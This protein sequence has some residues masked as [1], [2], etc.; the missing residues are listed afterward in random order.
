MRLC[1]EA[2]KGVETEPRPRFGHLLG[3]GRGAEFAIS[4]L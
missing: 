3:W 2:M 4:V 1:P